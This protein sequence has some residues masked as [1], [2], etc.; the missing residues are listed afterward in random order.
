MGTL[1]DLSNP[2][3]HRILTIIQ[4]TQILSVEPT[5]QGP[6][7]IRPETEGR[8]TLFHIAVNPRPDTMNV[9]TDVTFEIAFDDGAP[10]I[11][12]VQKLV[13]TVRNVLDIFAP[14]F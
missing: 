14:D 6:V 4:A 11:E 2:D 1:R 7:I 3:K 12:T 5:S 9:N 13:A 10:A 8:T